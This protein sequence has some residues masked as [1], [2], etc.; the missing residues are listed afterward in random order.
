[1][2]EGSTIVLRAKRARKILQPRPLWVKLRP[3]S[4][5]LA[6]DFLLYLSINPFSI[7][8]YAKHAKVSHRTSY[9][10]FPAREQGSI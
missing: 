10:C 7:K 4:I 8:I 5:V 1:M 2:K 6:R 9:L 3:F